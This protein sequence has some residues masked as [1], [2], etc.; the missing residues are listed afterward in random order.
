[1]NISKSLPP[2]HQRKL[3]YLIPL[4]GWFAII[5]YPC[6]S[7]K[8]RAQ[9]ETE[10]GIIDQIKR[11]KSVADHGN[12]VEGKPGPSTGNWPIEVDLDATMHF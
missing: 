5:I 7:I 8:N 1:M 12:Q 6:L 9:W 11:I 4:D 2:E 10:L 3:K